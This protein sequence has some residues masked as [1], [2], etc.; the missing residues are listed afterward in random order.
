MRVLR[1]IDNV[2]I[3]RRKSMHKNTLWW[4]RCRSVSKKTYVA[5]TLP[6]KPRYDWLQVVQVIPAYSVSQKS[7]PP[8]TFCGIF[9]PGEP[10]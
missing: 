5:E 10:A 9:S 1:V 2:R 3:T 4:I 7:N 8:K 6:N